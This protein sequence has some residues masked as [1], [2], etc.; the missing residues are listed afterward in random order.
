MHHIEL[1]AMAK[2]NVG[3]LWIWALLN[4]LC[5]LSSEDKGAL[6]K[7]VEAIKTNYN[8]RFEEVNTESALEYINSC[9]YTHCSQNMGQNSP[10]QSL[11]FLLLRSV[12]TGEAVSWAPNPQ[13]A[14]T[15]WRRQKP[16]NWLPNLVKLFGIKMYVLMFELEVSLFQRSISLCFI[17]QSNSAPGEPQILSLSTMRRWNLENLS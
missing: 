2:H 1:M 8:E 17:L 5:S 10:L 16:R 9:N 3:K 4:Q 14:S 11:F 15:R 6:A 13:L 12:V 7:L